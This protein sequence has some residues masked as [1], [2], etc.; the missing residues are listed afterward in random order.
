MGV[1]SIIPCGQSAWV[2]TR[3]LIPPHHDGKQEDISMQVREICFVA[4][5]GGVSNPQVWPAR[6]VVYST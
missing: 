3:L 2:G 6:D 4:H 1:Y 5:L